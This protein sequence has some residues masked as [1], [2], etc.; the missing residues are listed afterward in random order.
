MFHGAM[1]II[2]I[3]QYKHTVVALKVM[4]N[5][6]D[7]SCVAILVS[8]EFIQVVEEPVGAILAVEYGGFVLFS[9]FAAHKDWRLNPMLVGCCFVI[10]V[11]EEGFV[12]FDVT[13]TT[14]GCDSQNVSIT[15]LGGGYTQNFGFIF[16]LCNGL[17][18]TLVCFL[19]YILETE[20]AFGKAT[21]V[22]I[23][24]VRCI[25]TSQVRGTFVKTTANQTNLPYFAPTALR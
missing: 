18:V 2:E 13:S 19:G 23:F 17:N 3:L 4:K 20:G 8:S 7:L 10:C 21:L 15:N 5:H 16:I 1:I 11:N 12:R 25:F 14:V 9:T 24:G 22:M 6:D